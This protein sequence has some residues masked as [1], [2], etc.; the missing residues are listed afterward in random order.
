MIEMI[1]QNEARGTNQSAL[2]LVDFYVSMRETIPNL[3]MAAFAE[4][5]QDAGFFEHVMMEIPQPEIDP[6]AFARNNE[7][8][9]GNRNAQPKNANNATGQQARNQ[10]TQNQKTSADRFKKPNPNDHFL[11]K[12]EI[13]NYSDISEVRDT[14]ARRNKR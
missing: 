14:N 1:Q 10:K 11:D 9:N 5:F 2:D 4:F 7:V 6:R 13:S 12:S 8:R 3:D